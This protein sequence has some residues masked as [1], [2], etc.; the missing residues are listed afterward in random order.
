LAARVGKR[1]TAGAQRVHPA[2]RFHRS[3]RRRAGTA[4]VPARLEPHLTAH[5]VARRR[6]PRTPRWCSWGFEG[7]VLK[8]PSSIYQGGRQSAWLKHNG[9]RPNCSSRHAPSE[10]RK[11]RLVHVVCLALLR[12]G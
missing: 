11:H 5:R 1:L 7:S 9:R 10:V 6:R 8:R 4:L 3:R 12:P 2:S